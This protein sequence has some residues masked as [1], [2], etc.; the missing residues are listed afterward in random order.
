M[1]LAQ[2]HNKVGLEPATP[3]SWVKHSTT[4]PLRSRTLFAI[5]LIFLLKKNPY[6][7]QWNW[8]FYWLF[9]IYRKFIKYSKGDIHWLKRSQ[10]FDFRI[11]MTFLYYAQYL[12]GLWQIA[13][14]NKDWHL[15]FTWLSMLPSPLIQNSFVKFPYKK[16]LSKTAFKCCTYLSK[17]FIKR[18]PHAEHVALFLFADWVRSM[19]LSMRGCILQGWTHISNATFLFSP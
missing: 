10:T 1:C 15:R 5:L 9:K 8:E 13:W 4:K 2:G 16:E 17:T 7:L 12:C 6:S 14:F 19:W 18:G 11:A 3:R